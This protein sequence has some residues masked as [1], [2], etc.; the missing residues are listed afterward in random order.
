MTEE[1]CPICTYPINNGESIIKCT[2]C[3]NRF[4]TKCLEL[5]E[6]LQC[7]I[8]RCII[9]R[10]G[11]K[12]KLLLELLHASKG[13]IKNQIKLNEI[14]TLLKPLTLITDRHRE[15]FDILEF[16]DFNNNEI[17]ANRYVKSGER[18][19]YEVLPK[20]DPL[21]KNR[22][23]YEEA[24]INSITIQA[25]VPLIQPIP[26]PITITEFKMITHDLKSIPI[27]NLLKDKLG[28]FDGKSVEEVWKDEAFKP[29]LKS[30]LISC[31]DYEYTLSIPFN[32]K[33]PC[34]K[35][36]C[37]GWLN[38][39]GVCNV[40]GHKHCY[41][42]SKDDHEY[43]LFKPEESIDAALYILLIYMPMHRCNFPSK[44]FYIDEDRAFLC[45][46]PQ[47]PDDEVLEELISHRKEIANAIGMDIDS[48]EVDDAIEYI[49]QKYEEKYYDLKPRMLDVIRNNVE[50][51]ILINSL[52]NE[53]L[54]KPPSQNPC[55]LCHKYS[56]VIT[57]TVDA[58]EFNNRIPKYK[59]NSAEVNYCSICHR[60]YVAFPFGDKIRVCQV[61][62]RFEDIKDFEIT[63][64]IFNYKA[65]L[66]RKLLTY[67]GVNERVIKLLELGANDPYHQA[68]V[69]IEKYLSQMTF[70]MAMKVN[71]SSWKKYTELQLPVIIV[72]LNKYPIL[73]VINGKE[74][75]AFLSSIFETLSVFGFNIS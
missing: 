73:N 51:T 75:I 57:Y 65:S 34:R 58:S 41:R 30:L 25:R 28:L 24:V 36:G 43:P 61:G 26:F 19:I 53:W 42:C 52:Q 69:I 63:E 23:V 3:P 64:D 29:I 62:P 17:I 47:D 39:N 45:P 11:V 71:H 8:C 54:C 27:L 4:H 70:N 16:D 12:G 48:E 46:R 60:A 55:F 13:L 35:E 59:S 49:N 21:I 6:S 7:P 31:S 72:Q 32:A 37:L 20:T 10:P 15:V 1:E 68:D 44:G 5:T 22:D 2:T 40:C 67:K 56:G 14:Q 38:S 50:R 33:F 9:L 74:D 18:V 66:I